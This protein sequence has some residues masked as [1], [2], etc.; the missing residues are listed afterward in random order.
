MPESTGTD[1]AKNTMSNCLL[2]VPFRDHFQESWETGS[3]KVKIRAKQLRMAGFKVHSESIGKQVTSVGLLKLTL[4][5]AYGDMD[6]VPAI[7]AQ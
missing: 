5:T 1:E 2:H 6:N 4:I 3:P 7:D